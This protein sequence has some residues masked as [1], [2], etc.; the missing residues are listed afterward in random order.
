MGAL[1]AG[2]PHGKET[3]LHG[4]PAYVTEP[5]DGRSIR[6]HIV[7]LTDALG[8]TFNNTRILADK[9]ADKTQARVYIPEFFDGH[10]LSAT[11]FSSMDTLTGNGWMVGK[12]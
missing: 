1:H 7:I 4:L 10:A 12:V 11:L 5:Q 9:Y 8:W 2:T 3:T 6:G